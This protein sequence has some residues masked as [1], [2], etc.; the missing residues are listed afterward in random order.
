MDNPLLQDGDLPVFDR[1][2]PEH[3]G[4][5]IEHTLASLRT[6]VDALLSQSDPDW[7][8][9]VAPL[10][11]LLES[12]HRVWAPVSHLNSM[13]SSDALR[14]AHNACLPLLSAFETELG[15]NQ[16]LYQAFKAI[17]DASD[18]S[19][20][21]AAQRK[22]VENRLRDFRLAG[23]E[24]D[25]TARARLKQI[26]Q[27]LSELRARFQENVLDATNAWQQQITDPHMVAGLPQ[28][29]LAAAQQSASGAGLQGWLL[30]LDFPCY[31]AVLTYA[32]QR[33]LREQLYTAYITR[34]S[35]LGPHAHR[36][37][38]TDVMEEILALRHES[39]RLLGYAH[40]ADL[41]LET[42]MASST[43][44][45]LD[46]LN[47]LAERA[48]PRARAEIEEVRQFAAQD[49]VDFELQAWDL[50][51]YSEKLRQHRYAV[52]QQ[53]LRPYFPVSSVLPGMFAVAQRLYGISVRER[54]G[55]SIWHPDVRFFE[56]FDA[57][58]E[59][60]GRFY[61]DLYARANKRSGAWMDGCQSRLRL[62]GSTR[63]PV[64]ML[65][66]NFTPPVGDQPSLLGHDEVVTLF[67][68]F[69]HGL[70]HLLSC[71][72]YPSVSGINGV[73]WDA[74]ELPSQL[75]ENWCWQR[76]ALDLISAHF[77][78]GQPL[79]EEL[80][81]RMLA[82]RNFQS[83][84]RMLR[85]IEFALFDM[86]IHAD[87]DPALGGRIAATLEQVRRRVAVVEAAPFNR[88]AHGFSHVFAGGYAAGYYSYKWAEVLSSDTFS[89]FEERG[90]LDRD[91]GVSFLRRMLEPGGSRDPMQQF[92]VYRG[93]EPNI[94]A[95]LRH[96]GL[97]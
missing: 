83:A 96:N 47:D 66:C 2:R 18:F 61:L 34:A 25:H 75:M 80:L 10:E 52:S 69:G 14:K 20:L 7:D 32:D 87:Y 62:N 11:A 57:S 85:Q 16:R 8:R 89:L 19:E 70:H 60:R 24:L 95:L 39:A 46:F 35:D 33:P 41:S 21:S 73:P 84:M 88:F 59:L 58:G 93:R 48:L 90:V 37:D 86:H 13:V 50:P 23:I 78:S 56:I 31:N 36:W 9:L 26:Q 91:T 97:A 63:L 5:A 40:F 17:A 6:C 22:V 71:I 79:P 15:Q 45:V 29:A 82:A 77:E 42:K 72:D 67:H 68:E 51:Y 3:V 65:T 64:A 27:R 38:N 44:Q 28:S 74:V 55:V 92:V 49:G 54:E 76:Q 94:D 53:E 43:R 1:V 4:P 81:Q 30:T 12:L